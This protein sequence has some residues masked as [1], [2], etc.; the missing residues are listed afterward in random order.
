LLSDISVGRE[1]EMVFFRR[2]ARRQQDFD[3]GQENSTLESRHGSE[4]R[5]ENTTENQ[6]QI[7]V[8]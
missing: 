2:Q 4:A 5:E 8:N 1:G 7:Y 3:L 6:Q